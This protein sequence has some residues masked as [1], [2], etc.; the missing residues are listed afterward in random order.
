L[1]VTLNT[2]TKGIQ[3]GV[4]MQQYF[5]FGGDNQLPNQGFMLFQP[6]FNKILGGGY[7][8]QFNPIMNFNWTNGTYTVPLS[9]AFGKAFAKNLSASFVP[10][11]VVSGPSQ[12]DFTLRFQLN[13]MFPTSK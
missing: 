7:F 9:L 6:I 1:F 3:L 11:Y 8:L 5:T 12:G 10:E 13:A 4:L 2:R